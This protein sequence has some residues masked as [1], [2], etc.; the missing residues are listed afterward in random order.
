MMYLDSISQVIKWQTNR[1]PGVVALPPDLSN[2][3]GRRCDTLPELQGVE[4]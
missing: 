4:F 2:V 3:T 1:R